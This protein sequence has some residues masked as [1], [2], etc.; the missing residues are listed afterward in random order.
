MSDFAAR[1]RSTSSAPGMPEMP[2]RS[3][4][5]DARWSMA[6][7]YSGAA[8]VGDHRSSAVVMIGRG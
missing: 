3:L 8:W 2:K 7:K 4:A 5:K 6:S 1:I